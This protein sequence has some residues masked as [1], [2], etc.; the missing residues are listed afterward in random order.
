MEFGIT[1]GDSD[2]ELT[3]FRAVSLRRGAGDLGHGQR[4]VVGFQRADAKVDHATWRVQ[5][6]RITIPS[7]GGRGVTSVSTRKTLDG[8][9]RGG[10]GEFGAQ[11]PDGA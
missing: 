3:P 4:T 9:N 8:G 11:L 2:E 6:P 10:A 1:S 5:Q 7:L